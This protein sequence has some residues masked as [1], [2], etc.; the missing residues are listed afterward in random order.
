[1]NNILQHA[2]QAVLC[3]EAKPRKHHFR[4]FTAPQMFHERND[5]VHHIDIDIF[6]GAVLDK[7]TVNLV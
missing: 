7:F 1:M 3:S 2:S 5:L 4:R 6:Q